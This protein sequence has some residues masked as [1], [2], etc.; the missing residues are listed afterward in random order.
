MGSFCVEKRFGW[1]VALSE[2]AAA[3]MRLFGLNRRRM[4]AQQLVH[5]CE[6]VIQLGDVCFITG[7]SGAGKSVLLRELYHCIDASQRVRLEDIE[8]ETDRT[9][10][11]CVEG[12]LFESLEVLSRAGLSDAFAVLNRPGHLSE[13]Q[14]YRYRLARALASDKEYI[15]ADEFCSNLDRV[16]ALVVSHQIRKIASKR[17]KTFVLATSHDDLL[18]ELQPDVLVIKKLSGQAKVIYKD[19]SRKG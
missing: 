13:G 11:D 14:K 2:K 7:A 8:L 10:I 17:K 16:T 9:L 3:V 5:S 19:E 4:K 6:L 1:D 15:F 12:D 18:G